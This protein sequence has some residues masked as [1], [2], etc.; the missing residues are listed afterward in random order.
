MAVVPVETAIHLQIMDSKIKCRLAG[1]LAGCPIG[2]YNVYTAV[3]VLLYKIYGGRGWGHQW[4]ASRSRSLRPSSMPL[5]RSLS[6]TARSMEEILAEPLVLQQPPFSA[7]EE[8][9]RKARATNQNPHALPPPRL[10]VVVAPLSVDRPRTR[11]THRTSPSRAARAGSVW[12]S[13]PTTS[14]P[15]CCPAA[16]QSSTAACMSA[17]SC[18]RWMAWS[19]SRATASARSSP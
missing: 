18:W 19:F 5:F 17:I 6:G 7:A 2:V 15:S 4:P 16:R 10:P 13:T 1:W 14:S 11:R 12:S 3:Q 8:L 9:V